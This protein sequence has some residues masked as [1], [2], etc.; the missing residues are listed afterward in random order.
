M[1]GWP[2]ISVDTFESDAGIQ[3]EKWAMYDGIAKY[4]GTF[5]L[6]CTFN[7]MRGDPI[8]LMQH[9]WVTYGTRVGWDELMIPWI[10][11][12]LD[13]E[14][15]YET[16]IYR[17]VMDPT[18]TF[19]QKMARC[20]A[21]FPTNSN[22]GASF[23]FDANKPVNNKQDTHSMSFKCQAAIYYDFYTAVSFNITVV[24][25]NPQMYPANRARAY[26]KI[27][28]VNRRFFKDEGYPWINTKTSE[29]EWYVPNERYKAIMEMN[30]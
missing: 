19:V 2:D 30:R 1:S 28:A 16:C 8:G 9:M 13:F 10:D 21:A 22:T 7:N 20:G 25:F 17:L 26:T 29:L 23:D 18:K 14:K 15:D 24:D 5:D 27:P 12:I 11:S 3:K 4:Y 6:S